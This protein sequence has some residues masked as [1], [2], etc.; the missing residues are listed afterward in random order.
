MN[1]L[2]A[3]GEDRTGNSLCLRAGENRF[4]EAVFH[5]NHETGEVQECVTSMDKFL[6]SAN[7]ID[8]D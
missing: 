2:I 3:I 4:E 6:A 8:L 5:W 1:D 7:E